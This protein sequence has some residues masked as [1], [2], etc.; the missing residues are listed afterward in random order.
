[1]KNIQLLMNFQK[2]STGVTANKS[3]KKL[4]IQKDLNRL[5]RWYVGIEVKFS[6]KCDILCPGF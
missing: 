5:N 1:M 6:T 3:E 2:D 4:K